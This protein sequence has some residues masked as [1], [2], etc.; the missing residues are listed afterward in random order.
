LKTIGG[1]YNRKSI[2]IVAGHWGIEDDTANSPHPPL[3]KP[4]ALTWAPQLPVNVGF[5]IKLR[6]VIY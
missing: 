5:F 3:L 2:E 1:R 4:C 6:K